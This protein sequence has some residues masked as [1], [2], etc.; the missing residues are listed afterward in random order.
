M[1]P[2]LKLIECLKK[3][4]D[5]IVIEHGADKKTVLFYGFKGKQAFNQEVW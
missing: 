2:D 5:S 1:S 4:G 3:S